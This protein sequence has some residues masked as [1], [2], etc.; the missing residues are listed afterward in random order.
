MIFSLLMNKSPMRRICEVADIHPETLYQ[1]I[2]FFYRQCQA[3]AASRE[4]ALLDGRPFR[5]LYLAVDRQDYV[6]NWSKQDDKRNVVLRAVGSADD[7]TGYVFGM[8]LDFDPSLDPVAIE[9]DAASRNDQA[10]DYPFRRYARLWLKA[11]YTDLVRQKRRALKR[12]SRSGGV[13]AD[14]AVAYEEIKDRADVEAGVTQT[15]D[16][17]LPNRGM[18]VHSEYT[19]YGHFFFLKRLLA[20]AEKLRFFMDQESGIRAACLAAFCDDI[21]THRVDAFYVRINKTL[22]V[23]ERR[24]A[25]A[26]SRAEFD[27]ARKAYPKFKDSEVELL[28]I[29]ERLKN[30][31]AIGKWSDRWLLHPFPSMSEPEKAICY[32]TDYRDYDPDHLARLYAKASLHAIDRFFMQLRRRLSLL[33]RPIATSSGAYRTWYGYSPYNPEMVVK[34]IAIFRVFYNY[35]AVGEDKRTPAMR[36]GLAQVPIKIEDLLYFVTTK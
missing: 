31:S 17:Q 29:R 21:K 34:L 32:L 10:L 11:D 33:E 20:G 16:T 2:D 30:M 25:L 4:K 26:E 6:V 19:L 5:R 7:E 27:K 24:R 15:F 1:R 28:L 12:S 35:V 14:I 22:T 36:L 18:Q 3:F 9:K 13:T 23:N 8:H